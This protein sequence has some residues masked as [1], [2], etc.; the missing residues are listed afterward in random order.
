[1]PS[2]LATQRYMARLPSSIPCVEVADDVYA[3]PED[4]IDIVRQTL[5]QPQVHYFLSRNFR[6]DEVLMNGI[7]DKGW[8]LRPQSAGLQT[9]LSLRNSAVN[10]KRIVRYT[11]AMEADDNH[12][13]WFVHGCVSV[14]AVYNI[15]TVVEIDFHNWGI[16][17]S[18][19]TVE[20]HIVERY[21]GP[22]PYGESERLNPA[23]DAA[24][25]GVSIPNWSNGLSGV[26]TVEKAAGKLAYVT[27]DRNLKPGPAMTA[28]KSSAISLSNQRPPRR[29]ALSENL[30]TKLAVIAGPSTLDWAEFVPGFSFVAASYPL[31]AERMLVPVTHFKSKAS[32]PAAEIAKMESAA[33][34]M[35]EKTGASLILFRGQEDFN[36]LTLWKDGST[37]VTLGGGEPKGIM[38]VPEDG[39]VVTAANK[40]RGKTEWDSHKWLVSAV[41]EA[42][43]GDAIASSLASGTLPLT[44]TYRPD[45]SHLADSEGTVSVPNS[46]LRSVVDKLRRAGRTVSA[47]PTTDATSF[48]SAADKQLWLD[49]YATLSQPVSEAS[50]AVTT[51]LVSGDDGRVGEAVCVRLLSDPI[52]DPKEELMIVPILSPQG[53]WTTY[54]RESAAS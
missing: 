34:A 32:Y 50:P 36:P 14:E 27:P 42:G 47:V 43:V 1:M 35:S 29:S 19:A 13:D 49:F 48:G 8:V 22:I 44:V 17:F 5:N 26:V 12:P 16:E 20:F 40:A 18:Y 31:V 15:Q 21:I 9:E 30:R 25:T 24:A 51:A 46:D 11:D 54:A 53:F 38:S 52:F 39:T 7:G 6:A 3:V 41:N 33:A 45:A 4:Y 10:K 28:R 23:Y 37:I 2:N